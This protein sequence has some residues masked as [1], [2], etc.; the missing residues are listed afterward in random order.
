M[1][2]VR[3]MLTRFCQPKQQDVMQ[4]CS[5]F[6]GSTGKV[7]P[8]TKINMKGSKFFS[9]TAFFFIRMDGKLLI[10]YSSKPVYSLK[11]TAAYTQETF[12]NRQTL[13]AS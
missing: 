12:T 3:H 11:Y 2:K 4:L 7:D 9:L 13:R 5:H 6:S 10:Q 8:Q 1:L